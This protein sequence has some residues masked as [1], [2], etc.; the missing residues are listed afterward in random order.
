MTTTL[1]TYLNQ[2]QRLV[3]DVTNATFTPAELTDYINT[4][5]EDCALDMHCVRTLYTG[6]QLLPGQEIYPF[7]GAVVGA[8]VTSGGNYSSPP[9]VTFDA[10]PLGGV[11]AQGAAVMTGTAVTGINLTQWGVAYNGAPNIT[12]TP[13][14]ATATSIYLSEVFQIVSI[15][16]IWNNQR[17]MLNF[18]GFTLFQAYMRAWTTQ[19]NSRPGIWTMHPQQQQVYMRPMPDQQYYSEWDVIALPTP[20]VNST[21]IDLQVGLVWNKAVQWRAAAMALMKNQ[22]FEQ[23]NYYEQKYDQRVPKYIVGAGGYRIPNPYSRT[24]QRRVSRV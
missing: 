21:D 4:A 10:A 1:Q 13:P 5:R 17:Y 23:A 18:R 19:F 20:L 8:N 22:N 9:S 15:T 24:F 7:N 16:N 6:V 2:V 11:T 3:H 12:F 14:G